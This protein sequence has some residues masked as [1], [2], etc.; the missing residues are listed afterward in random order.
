MKTSA[1]LFTIFIIA[2][3]ISSPILGQR[4][5]YKDKMDCI[6]QLSLTDNQQDRVA[7]IRAT[8]QENMIDLRSE[9]QKS[10]LEINELRRKGGYSRSDYL[11]AVS[12]IGN[13]REKIATAM[14]AH[15]MD[16]YEILDDSQKEMWNKT[17]GR[18]GMRK[19]MMGKGMM[20]RRMNCPLR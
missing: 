16:V 13:I 8:H 2:L 3:F 9:L 1:K 4:M 5:M 11:N 12:E 17:D 18:G 6:N 20:Q 14:A 19:G 7:E 15:R 10:R